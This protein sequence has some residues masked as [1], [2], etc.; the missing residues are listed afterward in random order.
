MCAILERNIIFARENSRVCY[1]QQ[2]LYLDVLRAIMR[3]K[4][5][6]VSSVMDATLWPSFR[7]DLVHEIIVFDLVAD[8][9]LIEH[10]HRVHG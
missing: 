8:G 4:T 6:S 9:T 10:T 1:E 7:C 5:T 3:D 2:D